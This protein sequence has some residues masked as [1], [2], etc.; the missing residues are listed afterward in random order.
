MEF[1]RNNGYSKFLDIANNW[2]GP[3]GKL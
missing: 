1:I 2:K 3:Y